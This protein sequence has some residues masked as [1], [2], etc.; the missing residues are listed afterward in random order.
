MLNVTCMREI[1]IFRGSVSFL[2]FMIHWT[3]L[4]KSTAVSRP[5]QGQSFLVY[6]NNWSTKFEMELNNHAKVWNITFKRAK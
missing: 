1:Y 2:M 3:Q 4:V 6:S 5:P